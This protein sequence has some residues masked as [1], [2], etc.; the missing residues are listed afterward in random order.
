MVRK[1]VICA[2]DFFDAGKNPLALNQEISSS[3]LPS[4]IAM[5]LFVSTSMSNEFLESLKQ[6]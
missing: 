3:Q 2:E 1:R 5:L 4:Q 6:T